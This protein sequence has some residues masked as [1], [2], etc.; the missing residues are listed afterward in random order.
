MK[1]NI[2]LIEGHVDLGAGVVPE[3]VA[4]NVWFGCTKKE[5]LTKTEIAEETFSF[6]EKELKAGIRNS[7]LVGT[8]NQDITYEIYVL[9]D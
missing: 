4:T 8:N 5:M 3:G 2:Y 1:Y 6:I 9:R 7:F